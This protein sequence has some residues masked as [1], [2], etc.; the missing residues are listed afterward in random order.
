MLGHHKASFLYQL[1][2]DRQAANRNGHRKFGKFQGDARR[3][4]GWRIK[5]EST[6]NPF[7][8]LTL[9]TFQ[10]LSNLG[11]PPKPTFAWLKSLNATSTISRKRWGLG[12]FDFYEIGL[13]LI[14]D[15]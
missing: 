8:Y 6:C 14:E 7:I 1:P 15:W 11:I 12:H 5:R 2:N 4:H 9:A 3:L 10:R 13:R